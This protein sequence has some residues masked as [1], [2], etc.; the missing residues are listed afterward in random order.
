MIN[1]LKSSSPKSKD[2]GEYAKAWKSKGK[3][4]KLKRFVGNTKKVKDNQGEI[5]LSNILEYGTK[6]PYQGLIKRTY[7]GAAMK[8]AQSMIEEIKKESIGGFKMS[9]K[10]KIK[11]GSGHIYV[12]EYNNTMP[13][14]VELET[15]SNRLGFIQ[16]GAV[17]TYKP[18]F[19]EVKD[20]IGR[21]DEIYITE[22]E[23]TLKTGIL[24]WNGDTLEFLCS[25]ARVSEAGG[26]RTVKI[27][28]YIMITTKNM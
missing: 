3:K 15:E 11:L 7:N 9:E 16:S 27:G 6:S 25:T 20:D 23:I 1:E 28:G 13:T 14:D 26:V 24:T 4:Y 12:A 8:I 22:E 19:Y 21:I 10:E 5:P 17:I 2:G 18:T